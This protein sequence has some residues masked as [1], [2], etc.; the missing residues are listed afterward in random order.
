MRVDGSRM[1]AQPSGLDALGDEVSYRLL[2]LIELN[3]RV[4][5]RELASHLGMSLG[6]ANYC[7]HA[8]VQKGWVKTENFKNSKNKIAYMYLLTPQ[9]LRQKGRVTVRFLKRKMREYD[10]LRDEIETLRAQAARHSRVR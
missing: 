8:L 10:A 5:Q 6:K 3:P 2:H 4:S 9:G 7:V 1:P